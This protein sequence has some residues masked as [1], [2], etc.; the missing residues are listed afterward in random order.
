MR[1]PWCDREDDRVIDS[2][3]AEGGLAIRRRRECAACRRRYTT[4]ERVEE[5]GLVVE[6]RD[7]TAEPYD[8]AKVRSGI[9]SAVANL[10]VTDEQVD[11]VV[12]KVGERLRRKGPRITSQQVGIE[13]LSQLRRIDQVAYLR[14]ASVYKGFQDASDFEKELVSLQ[15]K[16][17]D[18][19]RTP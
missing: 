14:F 8:P 3:P 12:L 19:S 5:L 16:E 17:S 18:K 6:K 10:P 1:C 9:R 11:A 7:G 4:F 13:V 2:R 15:K